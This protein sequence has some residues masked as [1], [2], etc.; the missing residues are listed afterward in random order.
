MTTMVKLKLLRV[1]LASGYTAKQAM[2]FLKKLE[3]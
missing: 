3:Q 1:L 2:E